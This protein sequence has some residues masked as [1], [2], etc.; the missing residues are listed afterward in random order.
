MMLASNYRRWIMDLLR[1]FIGKH[2]VEVGSGTGA[3]LDLLLEGKPERLTLL[4]PALNL[5][6][7]LVKRLVELKTPS[8]VRAQR[9]TLPEA[10]KGN[11]FPA[12]DTVVYINV[13]EHIQN[14]VREL[15][16]IRSVLASRGR[17]LIF[18]PA[19]PFLLGQ[20]DRQ[21]GHFRR[22]TLDELRSK[23]SAAGFTVREAHYFDFLGMAPWWVKYRLLQS[24]RMEPQAVRFHDRWVV[25][26]SKTL[27][28]CIRPP[29]GK[30][31][32]LVGEKL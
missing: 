22:Y 31:I 12:P 4:E 29:I 21:L 3:Y 13:L 11:A 14:D 7:S 17:I 15:G 24:T 9:C 32:V 30:N 10:F 6:E 20:I 28:A 5:Y 25:P 8:W 23:C 2:I 27:E 16:I 19:C 1:P 18:V 26:I